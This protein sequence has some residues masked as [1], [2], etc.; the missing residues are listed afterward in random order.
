MWENT[1]VQC[2]SLPH[3]CITNNPIN[4]YMTS[5]ISNDACHCH[6]LWQPTGHVR[7]GHI[8]SGHKGYPIS[9]KHD[10]TNTLLP[11]G[12]LTTGFA[13]HVTHLIHDSC[14][15][16]LTWHIKDPK[17]PEK[18]YFERASYIKGR[19]IGSIW[20]RMWKPQHQIKH[21]GINFS[22]L[23][24]HHIKFTYAWVRVSL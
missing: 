8:V 20:K 11:V 1:M 3:F 22:D 17:N 21:S 9:D 4:L 18:T 16:N 14:S 5:F 2:T 19:M 23:N 24:L 7:T 10:P 15:T 12:S 13:T 6:C